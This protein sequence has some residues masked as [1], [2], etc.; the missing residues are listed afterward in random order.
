MKPSY[1]HYIFQH[2]QLLS[3]NPAPATPAKPESSYVPVPE[4]MH[5]VITVRADSSYLAAYHHR[6]F[7]SDDDTCCSSDGSVTDCDV[8]ITAKPPGKGGKKSKSK[9]KGKDQLSAEVLIA[10]DLGDSAA[11][12]PDTLRTS[13]DEV[14]AFV[15]EEAKGWQIADLMHQEEMADRTDIGSGFG[16]SAEALAESLA[17]SIAESG[18]IASWSGYGLARQRLCRCVGSYS[19][20]DISAQSKCGQYT[21]QEGNGYGFFW[22]DSRPTRSHTAFAQFWVDK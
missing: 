3:R 14:A 22:G 4:D 2:W 20:Q 12:M 13:I 11:D 16:L 1:Q 19:L 5:P 17:E 6:S 9:G 10:S 21:H 15:E 8:S 18:I 7:S